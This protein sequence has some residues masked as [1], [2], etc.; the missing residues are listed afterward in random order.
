MKSLSISIL[1]MW[2][3]CSL[4]ALADCVKDGHTYKTGERV[5]PFICTADGT[6]KR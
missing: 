4:S 1:C 3:A 5:G 6:W 2:L